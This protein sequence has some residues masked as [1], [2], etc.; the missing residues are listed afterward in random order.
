MERRDFVKAAGAMAAAAAVTADGKAAS[1]PATVGIQMEV[2]PIHDRGSGPVLDDIQKSAHVNTVFLGVFTYTASRAGVPGTN[3]HG[4]N[5]AAV[6]PR[7]YKDVPLTA[8]DMR[9][10]DYGDYDVLADMIPAA[11][12]RGMKTFC[13]V[14]EDNFRPQFGDFEAM[15]ERDLNGGIP[16]LHPAQGYLNNPRYRNFICGLMEDYA[17]S[18][19]IDGVMYGAER[20]GPLGNSL[21][22]FHNG[23]HSDP[24]RVTCFCQYCRVKGKSQGIDVERA[25]QGYLALAKY[26]REGRAGQRPRDGFF[27]MFWRLLLD[28]PEILAWEMLWTRSMREHYAAIHERVK[29]VRSGLQV[30]WHIWHNISFSPFYRAEQDYAELSKYSDFIKPVL[31]NHCAGDRMLT[32]MDSVGQNVFG[33]LPKPALLEFEYG[34]MDYREAPLDRLRTT[35]LSADYVYRETKRAVDDVAGTAT[36]IWPGIGIDVPTPQARCTPDGVRDATLAALR[37]GA[38]GVLLSRAYLEM[39]PENLRGAGEA[40]EQAG[41][42]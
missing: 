28:Y 39:K 27:V 8:A 29:S 37:A 32:Y 24:Y 16:S 14:I 2:A 25:R 18:Y 33:D 3:F 11:R 35:G 26:V 34:V 13:W 6:H 15:W 4:G 20:Q 21:G 40:L 10:T 42:V 7:Y 30:G 17:R 41:A 31:Y 36:E 1:K 19:E 12:K 38:P 22:A 9:A 5:F 23:A